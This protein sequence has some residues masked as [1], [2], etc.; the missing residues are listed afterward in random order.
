M[1]TRNSWAVILKFAGATIFVSGL[2]LLGVLQSSRKARAS[3]PGR[4]RLRSARS[5]QQAI[6]KRKAILSGAKC[7]VSCH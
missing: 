6:H 3:I 7:T 1:K 4:G 2:L 5:Q